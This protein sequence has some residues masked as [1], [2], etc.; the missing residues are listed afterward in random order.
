[1]RTR[2]GRDK[3]PSLIAHTPRTDGWWRYAARIEHDQERLTLATVFDQRDSVR[4][5]LLAA[6]LCDGA[7]E[8]R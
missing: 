5:D 3:Y 4:D 6:D 8:D 7:A 2:R 1:M